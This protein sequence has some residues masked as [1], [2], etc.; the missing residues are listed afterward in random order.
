M[1]WTLQSDEVSLASGLIRFAYTRVNALFPCSPSLSFS[2]LT[3]SS[4]QVLLPRVLLPSSSLSALPSPPTPKLPI[5]LGGLVY[6]PFPV[7]SM[8]LLGV[9][10]F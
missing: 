5:L 10:L 6:F 9:S 7:G 3:I 4:P 8:F 2:L 1:P